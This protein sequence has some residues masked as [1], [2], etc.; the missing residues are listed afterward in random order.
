MLTDPNLRA[1]VD[2]LWYI[3]WTGGLAHSHEPLLDILG[4]NEVK[5]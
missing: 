1:Q 5:R 3:F 2:A 4:T